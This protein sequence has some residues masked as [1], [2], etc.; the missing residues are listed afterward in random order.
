MASPSES[1]S[2]LAWLAFAYVSGELAHAEAEAFERRLAQD[3][4]AREAVAEAVALI[5]A[6]AA[7][8]PETLPLMRARRRLT[9]RWLAAGAA[10]AASLAVVV[11]LSS[12]GP[13]P[14]IAVAV[15]ASPRAGV[16]P[17][18]TVALAWSG[19]HQEFEPD[20][21]GS[22]DLSAWLN[23]AEPVTVETESVADRGLPGW[24]VEAAALG[25]HPS[26]SQEN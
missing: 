9:R 13:K 6:V 8:P 18:G 22:D 1:K 21:E 15:V 7:F 12:R 5:G 19:L 10:V 17:A 3:Q 23:E 16:D 24:L 26:P 2:D 25:D 11:G 14:P 4:A 20:Q